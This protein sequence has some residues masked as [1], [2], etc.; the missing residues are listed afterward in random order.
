MFRPYTVRS[1]Y[2]ASADAGSPGIRLAGWPY[3]FLVRLRPAWMGELKERVSGLLQY[4]LRPADCLRD[5]SFSSPIQA[6]LSLL[7]YMVGIYS[8][9]LQAVLDV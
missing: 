7:Q 9:I 6:G 4:L 8:K 5:L 1:P 3:I 2:A